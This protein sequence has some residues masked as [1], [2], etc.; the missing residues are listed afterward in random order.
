MED[1]QSQYWQND[2]SLG[3]NKTPPFRNNEARQAKQRTVGIVEPRV[4]VRIPR[5][6]LSSEQEQQQKGMLDPKA[7]TTIRTHLINPGTI[8]EQPQNSIGPPTT[9]MKVSAPHFF[10]MKFFE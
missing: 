8:P 2:A 9:D 10:M 4:V 6:H 1:Q 5:R 7:A 3:A